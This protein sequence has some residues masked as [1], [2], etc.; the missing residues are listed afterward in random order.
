MSRRLVILGAALVAAVAL[1]A[2]SALVAGRP[3]CSGRG[4][5]RLATC[6]R[7]RAA[8]SKAAAVEPGMFRAVMCPACCTIWEVA[9]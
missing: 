7:C 2:V 9:P 4:A 5:A 3:L 8:Y 1:C 6:S